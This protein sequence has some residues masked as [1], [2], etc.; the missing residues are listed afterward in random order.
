M[1]KWAKQTGFTIVEL[2][3]VIVVIA[4]LA[5]ITVVAYT[6]VQNQGYDTAMKS[7][8]RNLMVQI[9]NQKTIGGAFPADEGELDDLPIKITK[10][11]YGNH[12]INT[13]NGGEYNLVYCPPPTDNPDMAGFVAFNRSGNDWQI[14]AGGS[15]EPYTG[16][17]N[18]SS[19]SA[20]TSLGWASPGRTW[21][22]A[23]GWKSW[24]QG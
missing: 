14:R 21:L 20:C 13:T 7:D 22:Y 15:P 16:P 8:L 24:V 6:G 18:G 4:I 5:A 10:S 12:V 9:T 17:R 1:Q 3:I 2:L 11:A 19:G 23:N